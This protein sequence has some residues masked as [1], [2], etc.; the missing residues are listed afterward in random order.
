[1][2][3]STDFPHLD[4]MDIYKYP[5]NFDYTRWQPSTKIKLCNVL[6]NSSYENVV[7]FDSNEKRDAYF[8]SLSGYSETLTSDFHIMPDNTIKLPIPFDIMARYNYCYVDLPI[9]TSDTQMLDYEE[10]RG[11]RRYYYFISN[12]SQL[13]PNTVLCNIYLDIWTTFINDIDISY[14]YVER[15][16]AALLKNKVA[17]YLAN[18]IDNCE[19]LLADD[20]NTDSDTRIKNSTFIPFGNG[21]KYICVATTMNITQ[22]KNIVGATNSSTTDPTYYNTGDRWG[23]QYGVN[24]YN[25]A[26]GNK[27]YSG[28]STVEPDTYQTT[29]NIVPDN[30]TMFAF[31][32]TKAQTLFETL[33]NMAPFFLKSVLGMVVLSEDLFTKNGT[34]TFMGTTCYEVHNNGI[35]SNNITLTK[36][37]FNYDSKYANLT[38]L[39]TSPYATLEVTDN[40]GK[41]FNINIENCGKLSVS[42]QVSISFPFLRINAFVN[43]IGGNGTNDYT[44]KNLNNT[45][46]KKQIG[47]DDFS[48]YMG[49][50]D[51]PIYSI[52]QSGQVENQF[53]NYFGYQAQ[54]QNALLT[55]HNGTRSAN[56]NY[57]NDIASNNT[58]N[59]NAHN[60]NDTANTNAH[61]SNDTQNTN[62]T[63]LANT[64]KTNANE[65]AN[66]EN[67]NAN[68][69][70]N[71]GN[72]NNNL[73]MNAT[74]S[75]VNTAASATVTNTDRANSLMDSNQAYDSGYQRLVT[76]E[77]NTK[78]AASTVTNAIGNIATSALSGNALSIG[79]SVIN[80]ACAGA[81][82]AIAIGCNTTITEAGVSTSANK[83]NATK[84]YNS[85]TTSTN[86]TAS[87]NEIGITSNASRATYTNT[88]NNI[89]T[90]AGNTKNTNINNASRTNSTSIANAN[91]TQSTGNT[92]ADN[93]QSTG[94]TNADNTKNV[95]NANAGY[96]RESVILNNKNALENVQKITENTYKNNKF[97]TPVK[98]GSNTGDVFPD[99]WQRRGLQ[100]KIR[101]ENNGN[102]AQIGDAFLRYG[103]AINRNFDTKIL[104]PLNYFCYWKCLDVWATSSKAYDMPINSISDIFKNGTTVWDNPEKIGKVSIY[105]NFN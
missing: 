43:G 98:Y 39:Y 15:T 96:S 67:T 104:Q 86:N 3:G 16:G 25:F 63:D 10:T 83:K 62:A 87:L 27:D 33:N 42:K 8:D 97:L 54:K 38:K 12:I 101:T 74:V 44:W 24:G 17:D 59:T 32:A 93:T 78:M 102:I 65:S 103:Y 88:Q 37:M 36:S 53:S 7:K 20:Y 34:F 75:N 95:G 11:N 52:Y 1:M 70:A 46:I 28:A 30:T 82:A 23:Y 90:N 47:I 105:D 60:L 71:T 13:A 5:N 50:Y 61:N 84:T 41:S 48:K 64:A 26:Y 68:N 80:A 85:D 76:S 14:M 40:E 99:I 79:A 56:T 91:R 22:I 31:D 89:I 9:A 2:Q 92:N 51:I 73:L 57:E 72:T 21:T 81:N 4:N 69:N 49:D 58:T 66:T 45:D 77:D 29:D 6:F 35:I 18:P 94:N 55:Y 19:Y 100:V